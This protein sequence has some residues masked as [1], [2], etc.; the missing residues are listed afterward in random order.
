M[1]RSDAMANFF[2]MKWRV[3]IG[4]RFWS[5]MIFLVNDLKASCRDA[6]GK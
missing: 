4:T 1:F 6:T 5:S 3:S 2:T